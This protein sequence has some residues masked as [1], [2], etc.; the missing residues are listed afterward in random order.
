MRAR[1]EEEIQGF[2]AETGRVG[3][4][5]FSERRSE[6]RK[7]DCSCGVVESQMSEL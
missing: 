3:K 1:V 6:Q 2:L 4:R 7:S 5:C